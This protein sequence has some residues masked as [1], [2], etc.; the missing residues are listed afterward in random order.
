MNT[1]PLSIRTA[2]ETPLSV[3]AR[4]TRVEDVLEFCKDHQL[5][6]AE[7]FRYLEAENGGEY[8]PVPEQRPDAPVLTLEDIRKE[9]RR[10]LRFVGYTT[11]QDAIR[12]CAG[13]HAFLYKD[14]GLQSFWETAEL[15]DMYGSDLINEVTR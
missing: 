6:P 11:I 8:A 10:Q 4:F 14:A 9:M 13:V 12:A 15:V 7:M 3:D 5:H 2:L 1:Q